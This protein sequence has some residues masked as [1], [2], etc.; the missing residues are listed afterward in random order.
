MSKFLLSVRR[1][2]NCLL[3]SPTGTGKTLALLCA[4]LAWQRDQKGKEALVDEHKRDREEDGNF[5]TQVL[6]S[7]TFE[8][9]RYVGTGLLSDP[10]PQEKREQTESPVKLE[11]DCGVQNEE[12]VETENEDVSRWLDEQEQSVFQSAKR[13]KTRRHVKNLLKREASTPLIE[14]EESPVEGEKL[15]AFAGHPKLDR[16]TVP[17]IMHTNVEQG[18]TRRTTGRRLPK[19]YYCSRTHSQLTQV[20]AE[21]RTCESSFPAMSAVGL[22]GDEKPFSMTLLASRKNTCINTVGDGNFAI[23]MFM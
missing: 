5:S 8:D 19:V 3:E 6:S 15:Q 18:A 2:G 13:R 9:F 20:V 16:N 4:S 12:K 17:R 23:M 14:G 7:P 1:G 21:L 11:Y 22:G 10:P